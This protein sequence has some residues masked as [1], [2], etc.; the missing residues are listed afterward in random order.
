MHQIPWLSENGFCATIPSSLIYSLGVIRLDPCVSDDDFW[1]GLECCY[2]IIESR[3]ITIKRDNTILPTK[4]V[5]LKFR[6]SKL[7]EM[8]SIFKVIHHV[9]PSIRSPVQCIRC[10][11]FGHTQKYCRSK[12]R[13]SHC[14][15]YNH[16]IDTC[17]NRLSPPPTML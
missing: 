15:E 4:L 13:C 3:R 2:E 5:E 16:F 11:R 7:P 6:S 17:E 14:G 9:S 8:L 10:L 12:E 1:D